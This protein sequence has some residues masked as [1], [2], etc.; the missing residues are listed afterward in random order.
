MVLGS[1]QF[2]WK[3]IPSLV[4]ETQP[5]LV[6]VW[7][8]GQR[9]WMWDYASVHEAIRGFNWTQ[10]TRDLVA[11]FSGEFVST[12]IFAYIVMFFVNFS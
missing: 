8:I 7:K 3:S 4:K 11:S 1:A 2:L 10:E 12:P 6:V 5:E 9:L